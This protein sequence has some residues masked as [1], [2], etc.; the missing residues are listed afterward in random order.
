MGFKETMLRR[1]T[2][3]GTARTIGNG[4]LSMKKD[5]PGL[6]VSEFA[7]SFWDMRKTVGKYSGDTLARFDSKVAGR[8]YNS[9]QHLVTH[10]LS[11]EVGDDFDD[12]YYAMPSPDDLYSTEYVENKHKVLYDK[13]IGEELAKCGIPADFI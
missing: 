11:V 13:V 10:V 6:T 4:F 7:E 12:L 3:G 8:S 5:N 9:L 2:P 1:G